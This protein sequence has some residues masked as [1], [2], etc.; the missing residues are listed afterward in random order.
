MRE[1]G[2][3]REKERG[4]ER[5][6]EK[7]KDKDREPAGRTPG[8]GG[9]GRSGRAANANDSSI[10]LYFALFFAAACCF[11]VVLPFLS[12]CF[13]VSLSL[14]SLPSPLPPSSLACCPVCPVLCVL[15][16]ACLSLSACLAVRLSVRLSGPWTT[17]SLQR[18]AV[19]LLRVA[20][21]GLP[22]EPAR[23]SLRERVPFQMQ[24][25]LSK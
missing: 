1:R 7:D 4:R 20:L 16:V 18:V 14:S 9:R 11:L 5:E 25:T 24:S 12:L 23:S 21:T 8:R 13:S 10:S 15:F 22:L 3:E 6:R 2:R 19:Y 17:L